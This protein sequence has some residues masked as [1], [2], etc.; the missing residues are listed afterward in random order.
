MH[1][2]ISSLGAVVLAGMCTVSSPYAQD[3]PPVT[4]PA[5]RGEVTALAEQNERLLRRIE[6]LEAR[7]DRIA[8]RVNCVPGQP[9]LFEPDGHNW[10]KN[11]FQCEFSAPSN[12]FLYLS[13]QGHQRSKNARTSCSF[14]IFVDGKAI[15]TASRN[16]PSHTYATA[17]HP[18]FMADTVIV[19]GGR[20]VISLRASG[21]ACSIHDPDING[22]F[23]AT[24]Q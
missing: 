10:T 16:F 9:Y 4:C 24:G 20:H 12:G 7:L 19:S 14:G 23:I 6:A 18:S 1:K 5:D 11:L 15:N 21:A 17:W 2:S 13:L 22:M 3:C 8:V